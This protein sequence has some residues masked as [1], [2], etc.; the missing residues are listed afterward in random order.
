MNGSTLFVKT[1]KGADE[2]EKRTFGLP[3]RTR[4]LLILADGKRDVAT[5]AEIVSVQDFDTV[6]NQLVKDGFL[7]LAETQ[8]SIVKAKPAA[9]AGV[10]DFV[11]PADP[12]ERLK[13]ARTFIINT[14]QTFVG[15]FGSGLIKRAQMAQNNDDLRK[16]VDDWQEA[17]SSEAGKKRTEDLKARLLALL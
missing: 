2:I 17:I 5:I 9:A 6:L 11:V 3:S 16:L 10:D 8:P 1:P 13:L 14:T 15:V 4:Q 7:A 12:Q